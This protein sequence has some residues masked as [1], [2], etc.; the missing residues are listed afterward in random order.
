MS[1]ERLLNAW[2]MES[3]SK[4][5]Q[6]IP[7]GFLQEM[8]EY[9]EILNKTPANVES[10][11]GSITKIEREYAAQFLKELIE[12]RLG[13]IIKSELDGILIDAKALT[14]EEQRLH[15][16]IRQLLAGFKQGV[17]LPEVRQEAPL[18]KPTSL[19]SMTPPHMFKPLEKKGEKMLVVRFLQP[20]P[21]IMGIDMRA[22]GPFKREDVAN[23]PQENAL[24]LIRRGI[25]KRVEIEP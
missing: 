9:I 3:N 21:A 12:I 20:L 4:E 23:L 7:D 14:P 24:N 6:N 19:E 25:A 15:S 17:K 5:I 8:R 18:H 2:E 16:N 1:Y 10:F 11:I 22:Y 13:K